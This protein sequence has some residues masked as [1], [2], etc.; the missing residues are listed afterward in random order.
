MKGLRNCALVASA[1]ASIWVGTAAADTV[2]LLPPSTQT[3]QTAL[4]FSETYINGSATVT[5]NPGGAGGI[6]TY[7]LS[8][9]TYAYSQ[10]FNQALTPFTP[11]GSTSSYAF[12]TDFVFTVAPN[13]FDSLTS[14]I[15]LGTALAVNGLQARL[16]DYV[17]GSTQNLT[18]PSFHPTGTILDSWST[19]VNLAPGLTASTAVIQPTTLS[20]GTYVLEIRAASVGTS[21]GSYSGTLNLTPVPLPAALPLLLSSLG[22]FGLFARR[23]KL[24]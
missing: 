8:S 11:S 17:V 2:V 5:G 12:Y 15:N 23:R 16:Y 14:S 4:P 24:I 13:S 18:L 6:T 7:S 1:I 9:G 10:S 20:A 19:A 21:G 22:G 3:T